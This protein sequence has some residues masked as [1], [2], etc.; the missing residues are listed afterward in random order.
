MGGGGG[1]GGGG[2]QRSRRAVAAAAPDHR[3]HVQH[4]ARS[5]DH[6]GADKVRE[7]MVVLDA[8]AE[9]AARAGQGPGRAHEQP[10]GRAG[11]VVQE[12]RRAAAEGGGG[13]EGGGRQAAGAERRTA[14]CRPRT[15]RC[16]SC[17]RPKRSSSCRCRPAQRRRRRWRRRRGIDRRGSGRLV[18]DGNGQDGEPVRDQSQRADASSRRS[19]DRRARREAEGAGAPAGAGDSSGSAAWPPASRPRGNGGDLQRAL[20]EQ[21]E[22]AARQLEQLS[23]DQNRQDLADTARQLRNAADAMRRAAANG[24]P[25]ARGPGRGRRRAAARGAAAAA[26][27]R[28]A[29]RAER[30]VKDAQR[31]AEEIAQ[32]QKDIANDAQRPAATPAPIACGSAQ[33]LGQRKDALEQKVAGLEKQLDR[34]AERDRARTRKDASRKLPEA[35]NGIRDDKI[36]EKIRYSKQRCSGAGAPEEFARN[37]EA[38]DRRQHRQLRKKLDEAATSAGPQGRDAAPTRSNARA[39]W[40]AA[41]SRSAAACRSARGSRGRTASRRQQGQGQQGKDGQDGQQ[42]KQG[43]QGQ[44]G[45][46]GQQGTGSAGQQGQQGQA[47]SGGPTRPGRPAGAAGPG[48]SAGPA[49]P[50]RPAGTGRSAGRPRWAAATPWRRVAAAAGGGDRRPGR[51][52]HR[53]DDIRQF[54]GEARRWTG[55]GQALRNMLR[56]QNVDPKELDEILRRLRELDSERVYQDV[57]ELRAAA[58]LRVRRHEALRVRAAPQ[59]RRR[60]RSRARH[61]LGRSAA[62][63]QGAGR[64]VLPLAVEGPKQ[65]QNDGQRMTRRRRRRR[66]AAGRVAAPR[67]SAAWGGGY[68]RWGGEAG[69][70][71]RFPTDADFDGGVPVLPVDVPPGAR[72]AARPGLGHR[73][74]RRRHQLLDPPLGA[75]QDRGRP[76]TGSEPNHFVVRPTDEWLFQCPF[77]MAS[78]P[79]SAGFTP[80]DAAGP[81]QLPAQGRLPLGRRLLG[82]VGVGR[83]RRAR[84]PRCC[85]P[86][87]YPIKDLTAEHPIYRAL[88]HGR[89]RSRRCRRGSS[90]ADRRRHLGDGRRTA[91]ARTWR[92]SPTRR[93]ASWC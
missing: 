9:P 19:A 38:A 87:Q 86:A 34:M 56:E 76:Q 90:G 58:D 8:V 43:Q 5:Q 14:R 51:L 26:A 3:R 17:S 71:P 1:G 11:S 22:E 21:A 59:G 10:P 13:D 30:D 69:V 23:R 88:F 62:G 20:A 31:Q 77:V 48:R 42:G 39:S 12:D 45:Q 2:G 15:R 33:M 47:G 50:G 82:A 66:G 4:A 25:S 6:D 24:D 37:L 35:A 74:S 70:P 52:L 65:Q 91:P 93:A 40:R 36:K 28:R 7:G 92:R 49:R 60:S 84:S 75:D 78:D 53:P 54:R 61:R 67:R 83:L 46:A 64:G 29:T 32:E 55:E 27:Q 41:S 73:L 63:V 57:E 68:G 85:R 81:A 79:G 72:P 44:Q 18:Q 80:E 16:S 89:R